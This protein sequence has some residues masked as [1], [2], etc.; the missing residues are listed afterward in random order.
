MVYN[1][2]EKGFTSIIINP[3]KEKQYYIF[4]PNVNLKME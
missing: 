3:N 2:P 1:L 4:Y